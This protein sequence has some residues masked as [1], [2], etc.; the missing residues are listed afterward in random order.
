VNTIAG[1]TKIRPATREEFGGTP[2]PRAARQTEP[3]TLGSRGWAAAWPHF[4]PDLAARYARLAVKD[5]HS[6]Q[7][8]M[9]FRVKGKGD[10]IRY[11]EVHPGAL[12]MID[13][14]LV[15]AGHRSD[16]DGPLFRPVA[17]N[18]TGA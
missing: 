16:I 1:A 14:Y 6:R 18:C 10:K 15:M 7:D 3:P 11:V 8:V 17:N 13:D 12:R 9:Y 2:D 5:L 4:Y